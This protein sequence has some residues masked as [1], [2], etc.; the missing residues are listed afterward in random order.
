MSQKQFYVI[1]YMFKISIHALELV[2]YMLKLVYIS[3]NQF[4]IC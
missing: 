2:L 1:M 4:Y 3:Q